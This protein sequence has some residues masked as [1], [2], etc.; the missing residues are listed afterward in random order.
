MSLGMIGQKAGMTR[1]FDSK[2]CVN[3]SYCYI[4]YIQH[5]YS[6]KTK[7]KDGYQAVQ[8]SYGNVN[9]KKVNKALSGHYKPPQLHLAKV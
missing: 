2:W 3:T 6:N 8:V 1:I 7:D 5:Y 4:I 9:Q